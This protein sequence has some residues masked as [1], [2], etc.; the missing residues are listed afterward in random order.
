VVDCL[1]FIS[2]FNANILLFISF[3]QVICDYPHWNVLLTYD[4][5]KS[6]V[7]VTE[8]LEVFA[9]HNI[10]VV[11]EESGASDTNQSYDQQQAVADKKATR[12]LLDIAR[13]RMS[14]RMD[15]Y[16]LVGV[17]LVAIKSLPLSLWE[18]SFIRV[19]LHPHHRMSFEDWIKKIY[20]KVKTG[21][22]KYTRTNDDSYYDAMPAVWKNMSTEHWHKVLSIIDEFEAGTNENDG[23]AWSKEHCL[24][25]LPY[26]KLQDKPKLWICHQVARTVDPGVIVGAR[27][28]I[29]RESDEDEEGGG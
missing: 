26:C 8:A 19:N 22:T 11:K 14:Q 12:Q 29:A 5:F 4:G 7:N 13:P 1:F 10:V 15:Q 18:S 3:S 21:E 17:I 24:L 9:Q 25:L 27:Q 28:V 23:V 20:D 6:H 2:I 16:K